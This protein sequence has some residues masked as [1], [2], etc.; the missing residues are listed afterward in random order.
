M[1][2]Q[3]LALW[4]GGWLP[5]K[6]AGNWLLQ[7]EQIQPTQGSHRNERAFITQGIGQP[8]IQ[9]AMLA[10]RTAWNTMQDVLFT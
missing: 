3:C 7:A 8:S 1:L 2:M 10:S 9:A 5:C 4:H 6:H